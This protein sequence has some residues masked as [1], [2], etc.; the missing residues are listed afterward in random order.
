MTVAFALPLFL[1]KSE[2]IIK[3]YSIGPFFQWNV[4]SA[5]LKQV[6]TFIGHCPHNWHKQAKLYTICNLFPTL[7]LYKKEQNTLDTLFW[8]KNNAQKRC[9]VVVVVSISTKI[10]TIKRVGLNSW[11]HHIKNDFLYIQWHASIS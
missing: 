5:D 8:E 6:G 3:L 1:T 7:E 2:P 9:F 4:T 10:T 11:G